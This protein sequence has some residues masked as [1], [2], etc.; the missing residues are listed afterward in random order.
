[1]LCELVSLE[2]EKDVRHAPCAT[3]P[4]KVCD[5]MLEVV[6]YAIAMR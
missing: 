1:V 4:W 3:R 6:L 5:V 2:A